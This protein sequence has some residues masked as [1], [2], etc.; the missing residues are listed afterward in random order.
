MVFD[1]WSIIIIVIVFQGVFLLSLLVAPKERRYKQGNSYLI[2]IILLLIWF[3]GEFFAVRNK[4]D[5]GLYV[6]YGTRYGSWFLLGPLTYFYF[7]AIT[8]SEWR[9]SRK[10][11][12]HF[13]PFFIFV[14]VIPFIS[15][16]ALNNRQVDYGMLSVFDHREKTLSTIQWTYSIVFIM[17]FVHLGYFLLKNL[18]LVTRYSKGLTYEYSNIDTKVSW[19]RYLNIMLLIV[20]VFSAIFLYILL[21][22]DIYRRHLDYIYV[23]PIGILFYFISYKFM[24]TEWKSLENGD[25]YLGS[26]LKKDDISNYVLKLDELMKNDKAYLDNVIRLSD[27]ALKMSM[28]KHHLSQLLNQHYKLSFYDFVNRFRVSEAKRIIASNPEYTLLQVA[29]DSGFNNKTSFVNAFKKFEKLT[30]SQFRDSL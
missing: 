28:S 13:L 20:L 26:S 25:K 14:I 23:L 8:I 29:F 22:T 11:L 30:P 27:L 7:K 1:I 12:W 16:K 21:V 24:R 10:E 2:V 5:I 19:L 3:L 18:T 9:F 17:Q 15:Y 6:F 4:I